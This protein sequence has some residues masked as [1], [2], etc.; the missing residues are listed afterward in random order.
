MTKNFKPACILNNKAVA[1]TNKGEL[2]P[3]CHLDTPKARMDPGI[4]PL[5]KVN[6]IDD[7]DSIE[8]ILCQ[9]EWIDFYN[10]LINGTPCETCLKVCNI[11][12]G[13]KTN[14]RL[15]ILYK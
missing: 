13:Q 6:K 15:E 10:N 1:L 2:I 7:Y 11:S 3:C 5:Y 14:T 12:D 9:Q 4:K 8:E